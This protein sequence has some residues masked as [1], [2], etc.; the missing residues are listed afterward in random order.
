MRKTFLPFTLALGLALTAM[1]SPAH[2][3]LSEEKLN[4]PGD[5]IPPPAPAGGGVF[6]YRVPLARASA[7][8]VPDLQV[9]PQSLSF[10]D[11]LV[12]SSAASA[13][14][15]TNS[16][17]APL[18]FSAFSFE[19]DGAFTLDSSLCSGTLPAGQNCAIGVSFAPLS[20]GAHSGSIRIQSNAGEGSIALAGRGLQGELQA[21]RSALVFDA[22]L[23]G[24]R[25]SQ[26]L[27]IANTGDA[28]VGSIG[29]TANTP[30]LVEGGCAVIAPGNACSLTL[31]FQPSTAG[32]AAGSLVVSSPVGGLSVGLTGSGTA[33][34]SNATVV[35]GNPIDFG[36]VTQGAAPV[37][38]TVTVRN[39]GNVAMT[40]SGVSGL[41]A[42]VSVLSNTCSGVAPAGNCTVVIRLATGATAKFTGAVANTQG[43]STNASLS[44]TGEVKSAGYSAS[45]FSATYV[46]YFDGESA[47]DVWLEV[48]NKAGVPL[49]V[50]NLSWERAGAGY[51]S[52][53]I[54]NMPGPS[55]LNVTSPWTYLKNWA[56]GGPATV[57]ASTGAIS[58][59]WTSNYIFGVTDSGA[60]RHVK[61][62]LSNGQVITAAPTGSSFVK[63]GCC[64]YRKAVTLTIN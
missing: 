55:F 24:Q 25:V 2:A 17:S 9:S 10:A 35:A 53:W 63:E 40:L 41:P 5:F 43:A 47:S 60:S 59:P 3:Q 50:T 7:A 34:V 6:L 64:V 29:Y 28:P 11:Q 37:D 32:T 38:R 36:S 19:G 33:A 20:R 62:T 16:G 15:L 4:T 49:T 30:F 51:N 14:L 26:A 12:G 54:Q 31:H 22:T 48:S 42:G 18:T 44:L 52:G 23:V 13:I 46:Y 1:T 27:E 21:N 61:I 8:A 39:D 57:T 45:Q 56:I 58:V